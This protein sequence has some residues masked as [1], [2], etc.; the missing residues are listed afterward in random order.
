MDASID[1]WMNKWMDGW[2]DEWMRLFHAYLPFIALYLQN[3][4]LINSD[5]TD[6]KKMILLDICDI[7]AIN[8][9]RVADSWQTSSSLMLS[10]LNKLIF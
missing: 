4:Q 6:L 7:A 1:E 5:Y 2:M 3:L 10:V 8:V 9:L